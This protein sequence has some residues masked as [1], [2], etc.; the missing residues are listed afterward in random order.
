MKYN[1]GN[2][3]HFNAADIIKSHGN[4]I[5]TRGVLSLIKRKGS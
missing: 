2:P 1:K 5:A 3:T 4:P